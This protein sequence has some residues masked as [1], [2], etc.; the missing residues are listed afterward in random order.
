MKVD[1]G[2]LLAFSSETSPGQET[3][4]S[5]S[6][7]PASSS[8]QRV[9][10][11]A[12]ATLV[13]LQAAPTFFWVTD[14]FT[15]AAA[16]ASTVAAGVPAPAPFLAAAPCVPAAP[17][18]AAA[19][20]AAP[21]GAAA[22]AATAAA[23]P[24][25]PA[26]VAGLLSV[27]TP[28]PMRVYVRGRL[29]GTTEA[30]TIMLPVGTHELTLENTN[31]GFQA[32][33]SVTVQAGRTTSVRLEAPSG[34]MNVN[35]VPWAEVWVAGKRLGETPLGNLQMP[36]GSHEVVFRHPDLGERRTTVLVT[37]KGPARVSMDLRTK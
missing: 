1:D 15:G 16:S 8:Q 29:V 2:G 13:L 35:A 14:R 5:V 18:E 32:R 34:T 30:D 37:L 7:A 3:A 11:A 4:S 33:R 28:V 20:A 27:E 31:V 36:I 23:A 10:I 17:E 12:L 6:T 19:D 22:A 21:D 24:R 26:M 25:P 9:M